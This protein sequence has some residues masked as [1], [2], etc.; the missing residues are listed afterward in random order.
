MEEVL[1]EEYTDTNT[2]HLGEEKQKHRKGNR[3]L[4]LFTTAKEGYSER[5]DGNKRD[6]EHDLEG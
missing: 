5:Y 2:N 6:N 1:S 3:V 4:R